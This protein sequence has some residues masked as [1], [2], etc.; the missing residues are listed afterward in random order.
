M[1]N[2]LKKKFDILKILGDI[3]IAFGIISLVIFIIL[4]GFLPF[5]KTNLIIIIG[6]GIYALTTFL[7]LLLITIACK[8]MLKIE[9][10]T[11]N[12]N[13]QKEN[14]KLFYE[15]MQDKISK[16]ENQIKE[17]KKNEKE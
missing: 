12:I 11:E 14:N 7:V 15:I 4:L 16:L 6:F 8:R 1:K 5:T 10:F 2:T 9:N 3:T 17:L 13:E